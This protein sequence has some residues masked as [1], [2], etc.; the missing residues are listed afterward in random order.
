MFFLP[1]TGG[2]VASDPP[3]GSILACDSSNV[4]N[5]RQF[6][7]G[8]TGVESPL[9]IFH[10]TTLSGPLGLGEKRKGEIRPLMTIGHKEDALF[11][12]GLLL[13]LDE[14]PDSPVGQLQ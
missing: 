6:R 4:A 9:D 8:V 7:C 14:F 1:Q 12:E 5:I 11:L 3:H 13:D 2:N 10:G